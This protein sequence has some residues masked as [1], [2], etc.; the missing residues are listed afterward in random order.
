MVKKFRINH[1]TQ[2]SAN[3]NV[4]TLSPSCTLVTTATSGSSSS[5]TTSDSSSQT[6]TSSAS[7]KRILSVESLNPPVQNLKKLKENLIQKHKPTP[8]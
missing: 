3:N 1:V 6:T 8:S 7:V 2:E 4:S 5:T